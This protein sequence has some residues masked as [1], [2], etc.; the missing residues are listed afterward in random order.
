VEALTSML[1]PIML[2]LLGGMVGYFLVAMYLPIF[3]LAGAV[4]A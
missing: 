1:E 3:G 2:V 4:S